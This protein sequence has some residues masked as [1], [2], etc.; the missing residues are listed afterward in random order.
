MPDESQIPV[1]TQFSP[2]LVSLRH[3]V[4]ALITYE[5][6]REHLLDA[7]NSPPVRLGAGEERTPTK[8]T[9]ALPLEA[10]V[11]YGLV[12]RATLLATELTRALA[13][14]DKSQQ[15]DAFARHILLNLGGLRVVQGAE[16]MND[17]RRP[18]NNRGYT[19]SAPYAAGVFRSRTQHRHQHVKNVAGE[20]RRVP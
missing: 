14:M 16:E 11:Q 13:K 18:V 12:E 17:C 19:G 10:A 4:A 20:G 5:G 7:I 3:L 1:G 9:R 2:A 15:H 8:R 6:Q